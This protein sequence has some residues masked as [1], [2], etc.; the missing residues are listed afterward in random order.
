MGNH[1]SIKAESLR[2][3]EGILVPRGLPLACPGAAAAQIQAAAHL[4]HRPMTKDSCR[5]SSRPPASALTGFGVVNAPE[6]FLQ[7]LFEKLGGD[8]DVAGTRPILKELQ[9]FLQR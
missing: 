5:R 6:C 2:D 4:C 9:A 1:V 7:R 8:G 3:K